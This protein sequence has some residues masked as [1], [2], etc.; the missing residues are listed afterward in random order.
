MLEL[1]PDCPL[2]IYANYLSYE[3]YTTTP[4]KKTALRIC[5]ELRAIG[6]KY[7]NECKHFKGESLDSFLA[8]I[9]VFEE[10]QQYV[11]D[12]LVAGGID[13]FHADPLNPEG[14]APRLIS[15]IWRNVK[16]PLDGQRCS[17]SWKETA[18]YF[19]ESNLRSPPAPI[20]S[21]HFSLKAF[22]ELTK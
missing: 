7:G 8:P 6:K 5:Q 16:H 14:L 19:I 11:H 22:T 9:N 20:N 4:N 13:N 10:I 15:Q 2:I 12:R 17:P 3:S 21:K 18:D 1:C